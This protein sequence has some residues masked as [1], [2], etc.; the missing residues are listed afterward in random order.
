MNA[1]QAKQTGVTGASGAHGQR[2]NVGGR[3]NQR[4]DTDLDAVAEQQLQDHKSGATPLAPVGRVERL[5]VD[6]AQVRKD[7]ALT[8]GAFAK[9]FGFSVSAVRNWEQG[10]RVPDRAATLLLRMIQ[11]EP[12]RVARIAQEMP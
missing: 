3:S 2:R 7:L 8:Q 1:K 5:F 6:V 11:E 4:T 10:R 12:Q 9:R